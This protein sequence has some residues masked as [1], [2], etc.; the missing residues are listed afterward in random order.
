[1]KVAIAEFRSQLTPSEQPYGSLFA[2]ADRSMLVDIKELKLLSDFD[3]PNV[4]RFLGVSIPE[5][6]REVP[7]MIISELCT[8][9]DLFDYIR[10]VPP[11][12]LHKVI[13]LMLDI[14]RGVEYLHLHKPSIIHR[15]CKSSN[16]LITAKITAK[17]TDFGLAKVKQSTRSMVRSLVGTVNW[18]AP[19]LWSPHPKYNHKVDVFSCA[20]VYW[21]MLQWHNTTKKFPWEVRLCDCAS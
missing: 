10:N 9:G 14:A 17:I 8:N 7:V 15:D 21:E 16:I 5:N 19:E 13:S 4:V 12:S 6:S 3:H 2:R 18:Q 11:P 1:M 20:C